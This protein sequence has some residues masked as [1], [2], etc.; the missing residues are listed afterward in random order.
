MAAQTVNHAHAEPEPLLGS[1]LGALDALTHEASLRIQGDLCAYTAAEHGRQLADL[2]DQGYIRLRIELGE[3]VLCTS[4]GL[5]CW[6]D[7]QHRLT[8]LDGTL[9]LAGATGVVRRVLD[10]VTRPEGHFCPT[11]E[12]AA[13]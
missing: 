9:T 11:V 6:D 5:D 7:L 1:V 10:V 8:T 2:V 12:A 3:L 4:D 13:A